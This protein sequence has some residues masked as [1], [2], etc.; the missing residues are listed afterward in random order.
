MLMS[1]GG[2]GVASSSRPVV[3]GLG[4]RP[5]SDSFAPEEAAE[6]FGLSERDKETFAAVM[7]MV[8]G[9]LA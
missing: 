6:E 7:E 5:V 9:C 8:I 3:V 2:S 4:L 1:G